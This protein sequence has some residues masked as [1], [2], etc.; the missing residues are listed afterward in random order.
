MPLPSNFPEPIYG[1]GAAA[2]AAVAGAEVAGA[3][4]AEVA[5]AAGAEVAGA[6]V[7]AGVPQAESSML[8]TIRKLTTINN[9]R[10][11]FSFSKFLNGYEKGRN[12]TRQ[13]VELSPPF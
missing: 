12:Q 8:A 11:I 10:I 9:L 2:G 3:A 13:F 7:V 4:G 5:G 1:F 6:A